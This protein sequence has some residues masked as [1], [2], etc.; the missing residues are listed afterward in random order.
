MV[1]KIYKIIKEETIIEK[2]ELT[3]RLK[4]SDE[5]VEDGLK[6]LESLGLVDLINLD[7]KNNCC[8]SCASCSGC[9]KF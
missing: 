4:V 5:I 8:I 1:Y 9:L 7:G 3:K 6:A 2:G